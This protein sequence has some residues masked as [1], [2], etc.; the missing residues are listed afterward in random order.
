MITHLWP[1]SRNPLCRTRIIVTYLFDFRFIRCTKWGVNQH[2]TQDT[3][4]FYSTVLLSTI[5]WLW[6]VAPLRDPP[7]IPESHKLIV[8]LILNHRS[9][10]THLI[11]PSSITDESNVKVMRIGNMIG[12]WRSS[13]S[14]PS[15]ST[16]ENVKRTVWRICILMV[17]PKGFLDLQDSLYIAK[18]WPRSCN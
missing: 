3:F 2:F 16:K 13:W 12:N 17:R 18:S 10:H 9:D 5:T 6:T 14:W 4:A 15:D 7:F 8:E 11:S 1:V